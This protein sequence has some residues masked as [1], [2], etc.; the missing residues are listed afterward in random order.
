MLVIVIE[1]LAP[2]LFFFDYEH[3]HASVAGKYD[4]YQQT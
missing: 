1:G 2:Y 4:R 3:K